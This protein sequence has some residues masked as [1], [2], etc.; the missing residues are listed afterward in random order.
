MRPTRATYLARAG[1]A[2]RAELAA[3]IDGYLARSPG[4]EWDAEAYKGSAAERVAESVGR[5]LLG[6]SGM[7]PAVLPRLRHQAKLT[8]KQVVERLSAALGAGGREAKVASYYHEMEHGELDSRRVSTRVLAALGEI[9][10]TTAEKLREI[11]EPQ[12]SGAPAAGGA[13]APAM[14]RK[15]T[16]DRGLRHV[17]GRAKNSD[18]SRWRR[19]RRET[20]ST[21]CSRA[22]LSG[23]LVVF[24]V[25]R[26]S[27][28]AGADL[29]SMTLQAATRPFLLFR[30]ALREGDFRLAELITR[31]LWRGRGDR[32]RG[33]S[34]RE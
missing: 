2:D 15:A 29:A 17:R 13:P 20:R 23:P 30:F 10:G 32:R 26:Q 25:R 6:S 7:W 28:P 21:N 27:V 18:P 16:P 3:L 14:A 1:D 22:A 33:H 31:V 11:G 8:R 19:R 34:P 4:R 24:E 12:G 9:Y 5:S